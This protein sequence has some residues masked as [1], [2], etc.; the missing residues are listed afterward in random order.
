MR[1]PATWLDRHTSEGGAVRFSTFPLSLLYVHATGSL[2]PEPIRYESARSAEWYVVQ[3]RVGML[4]AVDRAL[5]ER[6]RPAFVRSKLGV[7]L[8]WVFRHE[9]FVRFCQTRVERA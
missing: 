1:R 6:G 3:N 5:I 8:L 7:P 9:E 2:R 4:R